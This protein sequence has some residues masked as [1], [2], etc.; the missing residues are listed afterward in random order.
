MVEGHLSSSK[1]RNPSK[2]QDD[3]LSVEKRAILQNNALKENQQN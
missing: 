2:S 1:R 3:A